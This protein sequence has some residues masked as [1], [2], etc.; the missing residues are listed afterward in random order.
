MRRAETA[1][2][3]DRAHPPVAFLG[4]VV[5]GAADHESAHRMSH[6]R[7]PRDRHRPP[8]DELLEKR[9]EPPARRTR[10]GPAATRGYLIRRGPAN[11][12]P[13][14][15]RATAGYDP[16]AAMSRRHFVKKART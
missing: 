9:G 7:D 15:P 2:L 4:S 3:P 11:E 5:A 16:P 13:V 10:R 6:Q 12:Q 1:D 8:A 14:V